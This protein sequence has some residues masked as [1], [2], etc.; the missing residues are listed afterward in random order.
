MPSPTSSSPVG[1]IFKEGDDL[2]QDMLVIQ[3][4][5][6]I[7]AIIIS[8]FLIKDLISKN[9]F[10]SASSLDAGDHGFHLA[11]K[12]SGSQSNSIWM[13][14]HR[15]QHWYCFFILNHLHYSQTGF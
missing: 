7:S 15:T 2:R 12:I 14:R 6:I 4:S 10:G 11:G 13:H 9:G 1:V 5:D 3:V 8:T